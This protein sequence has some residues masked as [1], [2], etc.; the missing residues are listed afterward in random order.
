MSVLLV[1]AH[2][3][4]TVKRQKE[5]YTTYVEHRS[6]ARGGEDYWEFSNNGKK[7]KVFAFKPFSGVIGEKCIIIYDSLNPGVNFEIDDSRPIFVKG[8][9]TGKTICTII[10]H[11]VCFTP[12]KGELILFEYHVNGRYY[13]GIQ[14]IPPRKDFLCLK[15][16][17]KFEGEYWKQNPKRII[18]HLDKPVKKE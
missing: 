6:T 7:Y 2:C 13:E 3:S 9:D 11:D 8:E 17:D 12:K 10:K 5:T 4:C 1:I 14:T 15:I 16:G 18:I